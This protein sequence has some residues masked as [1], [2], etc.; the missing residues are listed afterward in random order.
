MIVKQIWSENFKQDCHEINL[1]A[2]VDF[3]TVRQVLK[4]TINVNLGRLGL[5][6]EAGGGGS[7]GY[8]ILFKNAVGRV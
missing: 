1:K 3:Q 8:I 7:G 2:A 5:G 6:I 4:I